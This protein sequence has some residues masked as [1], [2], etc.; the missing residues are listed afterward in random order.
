MSMSQEALSLF[1]WQL[2]RTI[3]SQNIDQFKANAA[4]ALDNYWQRNLQDDEL[5]DWNG[6]WMNIWLQDYYLTSANL[7]VHPDDKATRLKMDKQM[8][9]Q[10]RLDKAPLSIWLESLYVGIQALLTA[11]KDWQLKQ[12]PAPEFITDY[13]YVV[14]ESVADLLDDD[15]KRTNPDAIDWIIHITFKLLKYEDKLANLERQANLNV[16]RFT[17]DFFTDQALR[18]LNHFRDFAHALLNADDDHIQQMGHD[19]YQQVN[20]RVNQISVLQYFSDDLFDSYMAADSTDEA[21]NP[22]P[23]EPLYQLVDDLGQTTVAQPDNTDWAEDDDDVQEPI[24]TSLA[25]EHQD[26]PDSATSSDS[27]DGEDIHEL[28][29][30]LLADESDDDVDNENNAQADSSD[31][32]S[33][34]SAD[35]MNYISSYADSEDDDDFNEAPTA[36]DNTPAEAD[37]STTAAD[38]TNVDQD[39]TENESFGQDLSDDELRQAYYQAA[40]D[41]LDDYNAQVKDLNQQLKNVLD[42]SANGEFLQFSQ[43]K[44]SAKRFMQQLSHR[45]QALSRYLDQHPDLEAEVNHYGQQKY[46]GAMKREVIY[47]DNLLRLFKSRSQI[48]FRRAQTMQNHAHYALKADRQVAYDINDHCQDLL[49]AQNKQQ[50]NEIYQGIYGDDQKALEEDIQAFNHG[51]KVNV[52]GEKGEDAAAAV[53]DDGEVFTSVNLPYSYGKKGREDS[54]QVDAIVV[55]RHGIFILEVKNYRCEAIGVNANGEIIVKKHGN[56]RTYHTAKIMEQGQNHWRAVHN[57]LKDELSDKEWQFFQENKLPL[58][59]INVSANPKAKL[60]EAP[61]DKPFN[62]FVTPA[63]AKKF[64]ESRHKTLLADFVIKDIRRALANMQQ[65]EKTYTHF[66]FPED[67]AM[68]ASDSGRELVLMQ[69]LI[70]THLDDF[71]DQQ[72][73][74]LRKELAKRGYE[75]DDGVVHHQRK[76]SH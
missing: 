75:S 51:V 55:N 39:R 4:S 44:Q 18:L 47:W 63:E 13:W 73:P 16:S 6:A 1:T 48:L 74:G 10:T 36:V 56:L 40:Q 14:N 64:V 31:N 45:Q 67:M 41:A 28:L 66:N 15:T 69:Q 76:Q 71:I 43:Q 49:D 2:Q 17:D 30:E 24:D 61:A 27:D 23:D 68:T 21:A 65:A 12:V 59:T 22:A 58:Y 9:E 34:K 60:L 46:Y 42:N 19:L 20:D 32:A 38:Q 35:F 29:D 50:L 72:Q 8:L 53:F 26:E 52:K 37:Y 54:N 5:V 57:V 7:S 11:A 25:D 3:S 33:E 62:R 70:D